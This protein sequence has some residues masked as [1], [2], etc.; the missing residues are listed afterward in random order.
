MTP[1]RGPGTRF[2]GTLAVR[3]LLQAIEVRS[4]LDFL[5]HYPTVVATFALAGAVT[6]IGTWRSIAAWYNR[7]RDITRDRKRVRASR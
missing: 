6:A 3:F 2:G 7:R 4:V 5:V 1:A